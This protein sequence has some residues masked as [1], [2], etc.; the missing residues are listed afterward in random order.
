MGCLRLPLWIRLKLSPG[1]TKTRQQ[2]KEENQQLRQPSLH[3]PAF[4]TCWRHKSS[5]CET[6]NRDVSKSAV[7]TFELSA[8]CASLAL[9]QL[10]RRALQ[11][12]WQ[13]KMTRKPNRSELFH[14]LFIPFLKILQVNFIHKK[15]LWTRFSTKRSGI[16]PNWQEIRRQKKTPLY[17]LTGKWTGKRS[18][19]CAKHK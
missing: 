11:W 19:P 12:I 13:F 4:V 5:R 18:F 9:V 7:A 1:H 14:S 15:N 8:V 3:P 10:T 6:Q 16:F 17:S 2:N